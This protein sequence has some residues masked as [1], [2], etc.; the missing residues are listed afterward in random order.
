MLGHDYQKSVR[1]L[2]KNRKP[3]K[4]V[5]QN[6]HISFELTSKASFLSLQCFCSVTTNLASKKGWKIVMV[7]LCARLDKARL[8]SRI[9]KS[10]FAFQFLT[11]F[12]NTSNVCLWRQVHF[13]PQ[14]HSHFHMSTMIEQYYPTEYPSQSLPYRF[15]RS[16]QGLKSAS[17]N[18]EDLVSAET[19]CIFLDI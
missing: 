9:F 7:E 19:N 12:G 3:W 17:R 11:F 18:V 8:Q 14:T 15:L 1:P 6:A 16:D 4:F 13:F 10:G 2:A 5:I